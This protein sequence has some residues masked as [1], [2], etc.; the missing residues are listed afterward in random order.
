[1]NLNN[2]EIKAGIEEKIRKAF[3]GGFVSGATYCIRQDRGYNTKI[4]DKK[5]NEWI[6]ASCHKKP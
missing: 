5:Y 4:I 1:M 6:N 2:N 3:F